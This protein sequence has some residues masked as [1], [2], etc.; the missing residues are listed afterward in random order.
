MGRT[1]SPQ[2]A[3]TFRRGE[4][5]DLRRWLEAYEDDGPRGRSD[6]IRTLLRALKEGDRDLFDRLVKETELSELDLPEDFDEAPGAGARPETALDSLTV[7]L[8]AVGGVLPASRGSRSSGALV[9]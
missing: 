5:D 6:L 1:K 7:L 3:F 2:K 9:A 8:G 4:D